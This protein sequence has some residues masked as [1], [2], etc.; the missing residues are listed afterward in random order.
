M[1]A[2]TIQGTEIQIKEYRGKRVVTFKDIDAVHKR[3]IGTASRKKITDALGLKEGYF[4]RRT[5][6]KK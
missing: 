5:R 4:D 6:R 2:M 1:N 3:P